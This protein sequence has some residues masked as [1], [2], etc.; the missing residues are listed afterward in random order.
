MIHPQMTQIN[1]DEKDIKTVIDVV[2]PSTTIHKEC[3]EQTGNNYII[4][5]LIC[6]NLRHLRI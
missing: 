2:K 3:L 6:V 5:A 4:S 1:A